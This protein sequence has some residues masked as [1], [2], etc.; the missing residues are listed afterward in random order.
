MSKLNKLGTA[1]AAVPS[2]ITSK[3][4]IKN[5]KKGDKSKSAVKGSAEADL[6]T[7]LFSTSHMPPQLHVGEHVKKKIHQP[8][9]ILGDWE[10]G[11]KKA[12]LLEVAHG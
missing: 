7:P 9:H 2:P 10:V 8:C 11:S 12:N 3:V 4:M 5:H 6:R 1:Q